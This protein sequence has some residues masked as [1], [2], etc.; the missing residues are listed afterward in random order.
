MRDMNKLRKQNEDTDR[1]FNN[2]E[3]ADIPRL[4]TAYEGDSLR[5]I[6][7]PQEL[8]S[9]PN[10]QLAMVI[11]LVCCLAALTGIA[12]V[13]FWG[14]N[15]TAQLNQMQQCMMRIQPDPNVNYQLETYKCMNGN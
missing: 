15:E 8:D 14:A 13:E 12:V 10:Y 7:A 4:R 1:F 11:L 3:T 9:G 5:T 2:A 6:P